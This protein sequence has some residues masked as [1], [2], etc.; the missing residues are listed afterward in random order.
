[1]SDDLDRPQPPGLSR[2][3]RRREAIQHTAAVVRRE[4]TRHGGTAPDQATVENR[5]R[6]VMDRADRETQETGR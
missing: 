4:F 1:M 6:Q 5:V 2:E 3:E